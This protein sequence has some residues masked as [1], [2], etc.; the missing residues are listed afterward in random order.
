M[1]KL[2][3]LL[4]MAIMVFILGSCTGNTENETDLPEGDMSVITD[5]VENEPGVSEDDVPAVTDGPDEPEVSGSDAD[6]LSD[7]VDYN[8][9]QIPVLP[10]DSSVGFTQ[11]YDG[12]LEKVVFDTKKA[13]DYTVC[14]LG[15]YVMRSDLQNDDVIHSYYLNV[16]VSGDGET[17]ET[18]FVPSEFE[19][20]SQGGFRLYDDRI[21][22]YLTVYDM[23]C[24]LIVLRYMTE[25]GSIIGAF[26]TI[27]NG[28]PEIIMGDRSAVGDYGTGICSPL[29]DS[30][31]SVYNTNTLIDTENGVTYIFYFDNV[32]PDTYGDMH[33]V[34]AVDPVSGPE[35]HPFDEETTALANEILNGLDA[36][37]E[38][39]L[40]IL[41]G[42]MLE[43]AWVQNGVDQYG[44]LLFID[45]V[46]YD[47]MEYTQTFIPF[48]EPYDTLESIMEVMHRVYTEEKCA[49]IYC[50]YYEDN[51]YIIE[52]DGR[53]YHAMSDVILTPFDQPFL[54]AV[55]ISDDEILAI[56]TITYDDSGDVFDYEMVLKN[57][58]GEWKI[59][60]MFII[61]Y[62]G[63]NVWREKDY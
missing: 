31:V 39:A 33:F 20:V 62:Y 10:Y 58:S 43:A 52:V 23:D 45:V 27:K 59:H 7:Y 50:R 41:S 37:R 42:N 16:A 32:H 46:G 2:I 4:L 26:Y 51:Q 30:L 60:K 55:R 14:L 8:S 17:F 13:G 40:D 6:V 56:T 5:G 53:L 35:D 61:D 19:G 21:P 29:S 57:E 54:N 15:E 36:D 9:V 1:K 34:A 3:P 25:D 49:D 24:P 63:V 12:S 47:G 38:L 18:C 28:S 44:N 11:P 22:Q 48:K